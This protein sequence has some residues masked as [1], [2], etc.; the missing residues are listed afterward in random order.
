MYLA[1]RWADIRVESAVLRRGRHVQPEIFAVV[2]PSSRQPGRRSHS[3]W[4]TK[5]RRVRPRGWRAVLWPICRLPHRPLVRVQVAILD[6]V[7]HHRPRNSPRPSTEKRASVPPSRT[8]RAALLPVRRIANPAPMAS[9]GSSMTLSQQSISSPQRYSMAFASRTPRFAPMRT[10][11]G[12]DPRAILAE[13]PFRC[14]HYF[15]LWLAHSR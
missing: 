14:A 10:F 6:R 7:D 11:S 8:P 12:S 9:F 15:P 13:D 4:L 1:R 5:A 2:A 3:R